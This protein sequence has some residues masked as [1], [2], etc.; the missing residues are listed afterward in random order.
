MPKK[1]RG[2][3]LSAYDAGSHRYWR[4]GIEARLNEFDWTVLTLPARYFNWRIRGNPI[5]FIEQFSSE[6]SREYDF[7]IATSMV[8][9]AT[10]RGLIPSLAN[11]PSLIYFHENQFEYPQSDKQNKSI[12]PQMVNLYSA[13]AAD[14]LIFNSEFNRSSFFCGCDELMSKLPDYTFKNLSKRLHKKSSVIPVPIVDALFA[15][16]ANTLEKSLPIKLIWSHRWEYDKGPDRLWLFLVELSSRDIPFEI[17]IVGE[18]FRHIPDE[19][20]RIKEHFSD[21]LNY[22]GYIDKVEEYRE[23][24]SRCDVVLSTA[25]HE[26]QGIAVMEAVAAGCLPLVPNRLSYRELIGEKYRYE[27]IVNSPEEEAVVAVDTLLKVIL[28]D[29]GNDKLR[30]QFQQYSWSSLTGRYQKV[31]DQLYL[32]HR[33]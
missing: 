4:K 21:Q 17:S 22:F 1:R 8:D 32:P 33:D 26:F 12:E 23:L 5:S 2:L 25:I 30:E 9:L 20:E 7:I 28:K 27:S 11:T 18:K 24:L 19:F 10:L 29:K 13:L 3:L 15:I 14:Q 16:P 6:L 31:I